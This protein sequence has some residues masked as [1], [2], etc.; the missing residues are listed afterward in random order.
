VALMNTEDRVGDSA[1]LMDWAFGTLD[2]GRTPVAVNVS[3]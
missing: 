2:G 3:D 1:A